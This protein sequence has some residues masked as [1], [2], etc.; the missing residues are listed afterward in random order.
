MP[1]NN[2]TPHHRTP[3]PARVSEP[4]PAGPS[5]EER[6]QLQGGPLQLGPEHAD[7]HA[8][9]C[10]ALSQQLGEYLAFGFLE[11]GDG[12]GVVLMK[13]PEARS[14][15]NVARGEVSLVL[16]EDARVFGFL[17]CQGVGDCYYVARGTEFFSVC[18]E[19]GMATHG[20]YDIFVSPPMTWEALKRQLEAQRHWW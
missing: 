17:D 14:A 20:P 1:I 6:M 9:F 15:G 3:V 18:I 8:G 16:H 4:A 5:A 13:V 12:H 10:S 7:L 19:S 11:E 2:I